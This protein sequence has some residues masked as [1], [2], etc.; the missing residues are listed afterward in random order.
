MTPVRARI[1]LVA[2][3]A[4]LTIS[5]VASGEERYRPPELGPDY[6]APRVDWPAG[7]AAW[8]Q[9]ADLAALAAALLAASYLALRARSRA[10]LTAL[11]LLS[12]AYFGF[13]RGGCVCP[14]GAI[15][16]VAAALAD[17][18]R[19]IPLAVLATF[20]LPVAFALATGRTFCAAVCPLGAVQDLL[21]VRPV[22]VP[23]WLEHALGLLAY[24]YLGAAV[25]LAALGAAYLICQYDP[26]VALFRLAPWGA[27]ARGGDAA[28]RVDLLLLPAALIAVGLFVARPYCR[29]LCPL[30]AIFRLLGPLSWRHVTITPGECI[31]CRLCENA[32]PFGAIEPPTGDRPGDLRRDRRR[33]GAALALLPALAV[34]GALGGWA[35]RNELSRAHPSVRL[36]ERVR[37]EET[38]QAQGTTDASDAFYQTRRPRADLYAEASTLRARFAVGGAIL[39]AFLGLVVGA[40]LV[41]LSLRPSRSGYEPH[42]G[43]CLS[44]GRCFAFCP[45]ERK[46]RGLPPKPPPGKNGTPDA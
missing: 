24:A 12:L 39:G 23:R 33:L 9:W 41:S 46:R 30:G 34:L 10:M 17:P 42:R 21:A 1:L 29:F 15:Q 3:V 20:L 44:C 11:M 16:D 2:L 4:A 5:A 38:G 8:Q 32:C 26:F 6:V 43:R 31:R 22:R 27:W 14:I 37:L 19:A 28:G 45:V 40:K 35:V 36:A 13:W 25:L 7:R 18:A